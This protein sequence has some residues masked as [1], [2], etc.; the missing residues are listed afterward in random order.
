LNKLIL[1]SESIS[2]ES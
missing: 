1:I 2:Q